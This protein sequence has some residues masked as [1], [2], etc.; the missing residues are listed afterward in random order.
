MKPFN[1]SDKK[2]VKKILI[3][4]GSDSSAGAGIQVDLK[5][6]TAFGAY[7]TTVIT[8]ITSQNTTGVHDVCPLPAGC[9]SEQIDCIMHD[10]GTDAVKTGMLVDEGTVKIVADKIMHYGMR[11]VVVDPVMTAKGGYPLLSEEAIE[12]LKSSLLP[13]A[14]LVTPNIPEA[15]KL[16]GLSINKSSDRWLAAEKLYSLGAQNV[17]IKGGHF[18]AMDGEVEDIFYDGKEFTF[19]PAPRIPGPSLHGSGCVLASAIAANLAREYPLFEAICLARE[20]LLEAMRNP[21]VIGKGCTVIDP[22]NF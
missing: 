8:A 22:S 6:V 10:I 18:R 12:V 1:T 19:L 2:P 17:L 15:E 9:V 14:L 11:N 5:V 20:R 7:G 3:I 16:T 13:L 21:L 4:G